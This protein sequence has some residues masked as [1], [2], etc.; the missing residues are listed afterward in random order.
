MQVLGWDPDAKE[1]LFTNN[2]DSMMMVSLAQNL[3]DEGADIVMPVAGPVGLGSALADELGSDKLKI[4][5]VD[6]DWTQTDPARSGVSYISI[7][8]ND[9]IVLS[10]IES[11]DLILF[12][13]N[14]SWNIRKWGCRNC[15][16]HDLASEVS[17][18]AS[19]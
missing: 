13:R 16:Y 8:E 10:V 1:G 19:K 15:N 3:Y 9:A 14:N 17:E 4:S 5:G 2:F 11:L 6:G 18:L 7:K 12:W